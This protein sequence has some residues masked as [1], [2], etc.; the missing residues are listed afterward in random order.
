VTAKITLLGWCE[1][2][3]VR[4]AY[5]TDRLDTYVQTKAGAARH[6]EMEGKA[7]SAAEMRHLRSLGDQV[8]R[9]WPPLAATAQ[10]WDHIH[11]PDGDAQ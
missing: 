11:V 1:S 5:Y 6:R 4:L 8:W 10:H 7:P 9:Q 2:V 3:T